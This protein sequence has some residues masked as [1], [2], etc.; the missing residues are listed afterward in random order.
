MCV[1]IQQKANHG[2]LHHPRLT[3]STHTIEYSRRLTD[4]QQQTSNGYSSLFSLSVS[5]SN[6]YITSNENQFSWEQRV[7]T[8]AR[9]LRFYLTSCSQNFARFGH[10]L[11]GLILS[12]CTEISLGSWINRVAVIHWVFF[13]FYNYIRQHFRSFTSSAVLSAIIFWP[14]IGYY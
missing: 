11:F 4:Q 3:S 8:S 2:W 6:A 1:R 10:V 5:F 7:F 9:I 13:L 14:L 12:L